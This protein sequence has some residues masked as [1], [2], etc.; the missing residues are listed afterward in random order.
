MPVIFTLY[1][2]YLCYYNR[3]WWGNSLVVQRLG[4]GTF[5]A[6]AWVQA[7]VGELRSHKPCNMTRFLKIA[8]I[9]ESSDRIIKDHFPKGMSSVS[10]T[11]AHA[12]IQRILYTLASIPFNSL[13]FF[14]LL[15]PAAS[16]I[17]ANSLC[18]VIPRSLRERIWLVPQITIVP[19]EQPLTPGL[20]NLTESRPCLFIYIPTLVPALSPWLMS[21]GV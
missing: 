1:S 10:K 18:F 7:L 21:I 19:P 2:R 20:Q 15:D 13:C 6:E 4:F 12:H 16:W 17:L 11:R 3:Q 8:W 9:K 14:L 5:T